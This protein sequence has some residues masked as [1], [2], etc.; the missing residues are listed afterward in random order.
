MTTLPTKVDVPKN[1]WY[2]KR[3]FTNISNTYINMIQTL[4]PLNP[5]SKI[6]ESEDIAQTHILKQVK[7]RLQRD[8]I[9]HPD[10]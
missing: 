3:L 7:S 8:W 10:L 2:H 6:M 4:L 5:Y 9:H 1:Y